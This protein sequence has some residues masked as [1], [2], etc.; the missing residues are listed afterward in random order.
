MT[1]K[2]K[3]GTRGSP[4]ALAQ[5]NQVKTGLVTAH[6]SLGG[7]DIEIIII[8]TSG[9]I[10]Q[11]RLLIEEGGKG[12][13]T[14]EI[15]EQLLAGDI[16]LAVHSTKDMPAKLPQGLEIGGYLKREDPRDAFLS[17]IAGTIKDL[18]KAAVVGTS[19]LR[20]QAQ[21]LMVRPDLKVIPFRGNVETRIN[22]MKSGEVAATLLAV[23]GLN[24]LGLQGEITSFLE[25]DEMLPAPGQGAVA[26]ETRVGDETTGGLLSPLDHTETGLCARVE[27]AV[28]L[29]LGASC[30]MPLGALATVNGDQITAKAALFS[31]DGKNVWQKELVGPTSNP[32]GLGTALAKAIKAMADPKILETY[33]IF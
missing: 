23:A 3:I 10:I 8:K 17:P 6:S 4:L 9:D 22:K 11:D 32:E 29:G 18:P 15:E 33:K 2:L 24:R 19:S 20:R 27:R 12:L 7:D 13:F 1:A 21:L 26:I 30:R 25:F 14:K 16:D 28:S 31:P 5:A